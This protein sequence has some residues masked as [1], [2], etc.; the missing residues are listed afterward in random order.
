MS[1]IIAGKLADLVIFSGRN[2]QIIGGTLEVLDFKLCHPCLVHLGAGKRAFL[3]ID[4]SIIVLG[5]FE[6]VLFL[7][8]GLCQVEMDLFLAVQVSAGLQNR[9]GI[10][11]QF[12]VIRL[13]VIHARQHARDHRLVERGFV[14]FFEITDCLLIVFLLHGY[15][16]SIIIGIRTIGRALALDLIEITKSISVV[17]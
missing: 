13:T 16:P 17:F 12:L 6:V 3:G 9:L 7:K 15:K 4:E 2:F 1:Q 5:R 11:N 10:G 8:M 14:S